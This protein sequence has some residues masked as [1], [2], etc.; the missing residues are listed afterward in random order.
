MTISVGDKMPELEFLV[1][2]DDGPAKTAAADFFGDKKVV[3]FG[4]PGAFTPTCSLNHLPG[5]IE[6]ADDIIAKGV[7]TIAVLSVNDPFVMGAWKKQANSGD[8]I[9]YISDWDATYTKALGL[10]M[11]GSGAGLGIRSKRFSMIVEN[12]K[13]AALNIEANPGEADATGAA[14]MLELL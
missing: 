14:K 6:N 12:G 5:Y 11:D 9:V 7:D 1:M 4:V 13:L 2:T 8:K 3:L 10:E